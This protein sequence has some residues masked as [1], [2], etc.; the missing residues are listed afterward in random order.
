[1]FSRLW[2]LSL[3]W[4]YRARGC[5]QTLYLAM[6][7]A[8]N[9]SQPYWASWWIRCYCIKSS[10]HD[11]Q[12]RINPASLESVVQLVLRG[13]Q[14]GRIRLCGCFA[15]DEFFLNGKR[16]ANNLL[17]NQCSHNQYSSSMQQDSE[18]L[19]SIVGLSLHV[20]FSPLT[21]KSEPK[22][23]LSTFMCIFMLGSVGIVFLGF[24]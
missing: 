9:H 18:I 5:L 17:Q 24:H 13:L 8:W 6:N 22:S 2:I 4:Q 1:M 16:N 12:E 10:E 15:V 21:F 3:V 19:R 23:W 14:E 20:F 7:N 11:P